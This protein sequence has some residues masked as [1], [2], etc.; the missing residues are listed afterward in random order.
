MLDLPDLQI[1]IQ[2]EDTL[3]ILG[4]DLKEAIIFCGRAGDGGLPSF[5]LNG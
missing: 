3:A 2:S 4:R 1:E 5:R